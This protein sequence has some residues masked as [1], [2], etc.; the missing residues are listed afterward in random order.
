MERISRAGLP[1]LLLL[2]SLSSFGSVQ[3]SIEWNRSYA[4]ALEEARRS[5]KPILLEFRC[6]P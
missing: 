4:E 1:A 3:D 5:G 6:A 2:G